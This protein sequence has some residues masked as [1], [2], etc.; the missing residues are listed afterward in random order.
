MKACFLDWF[1]DILLSRFG[2]FFQKREILAKEA[3]T[4]KNAQTTVIIEIQRLIT[5]LE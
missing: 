3:N 4:L 1:F 5:N 2:N